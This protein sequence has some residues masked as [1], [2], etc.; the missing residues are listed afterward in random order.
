M[1]G[2]DLA[3]RISDNAKSYCEL[4]SQAVDKEIK[5]ISVEWNYE[6]DVVD[7]IMQQRKDRNRAMGVEEGTEKFPPHLIRRL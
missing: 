1:D 4:L 5:D 2:E 3:Q 6:D 7:V